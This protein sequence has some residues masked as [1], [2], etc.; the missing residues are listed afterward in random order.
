MFRDRSRGHA[1]GR[2]P[3]LTRGTYQEAWRQWVKWIEWRGIFSWL[4]ETV[5]ELGVMDKL[6][7]YMAS[8]RTV[9]GNRETMITA[10]LEAVNLLHGQS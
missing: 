4:E 8:S 6:A 9:R 10:K 7:E 1:F 2:V 3:D 5:S